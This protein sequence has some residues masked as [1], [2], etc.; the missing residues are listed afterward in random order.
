MFP[1][2]RSAGKWLRHGWYVPVGYVAGFA[3]LL[4]TLGW[5]PD[6]P[7]GELKTP[8]AAVSALAS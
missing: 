4:F 8:P 2:G 3:V 6:A 5:H 1:E 7:H